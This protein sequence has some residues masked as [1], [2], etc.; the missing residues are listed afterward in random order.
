MPMK[1]PEL[2]LPIIHL[3]YSKK[4]NSKVVAEKVRCPKIT[5]K[6]TKKFKVKKK[7]LLKILRVMV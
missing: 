3:L 4:M 6:R 2:F 7:N 5:I 1:H